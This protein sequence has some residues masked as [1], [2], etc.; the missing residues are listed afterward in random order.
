VA[1][2]LGGLST[3]GYQ[4]AAKI[5]ELKSFLLVVTCLAQMFNAPCFPA[6]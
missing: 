4:T 5:Q 1:D 3:D 2:F 6:P